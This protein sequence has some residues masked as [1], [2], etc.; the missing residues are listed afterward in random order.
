MHMVKV[1]MVH[2]ILVYWL[3]SVM[4]H[5]FW[6]ILSKLT[7]IRAPKTKETLNAEHCERERN[8][9]QNLIKHQ[10]RWI[11]FGT[12]FNAN[13]DNNSTTENLIH[14]LFIAQ[15]F[16]NYSV[17]WVLCTVYYALHV[18]IIQNVSIK[19]NKFELRSYESLVRLPFAICHFS[20]WS[21]FVFG[22]LRAISSFRE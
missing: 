4:L 19:I 3:V 20:V 14:E 21:Y 13:N 2:S 9:L 8:I 16:R 18:F 1:Y 12:C 11:S 15:F 17:Y 22:I 5:L 6:W 7:T 10:N